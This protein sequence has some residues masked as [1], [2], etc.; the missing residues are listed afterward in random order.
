MGIV[1]ERAGP[2][3]CDRLGFTLLEE[4]DSVFDATQVD[5]VASQVMAVREG[6]L[7]ENGNS[8]LGASSAG[9]QL[10]DSSTRPW[11]SRIVS[12]SPIAV[13]GLR[14]RQHHGLSHRCWA[15]IRTASS[16][17]MSS[18]RPTPSVMSTRAVARSQSSIPALSRVTAS[19][20]RPCRASRRAKNSS[21]I[22]PVLAYGRAGTIASS[23]APSSPAVPPRSGRP[24]TSPWQRTEQAP[25][26]P[27]LADPGHR[28]A[29]PT[30]ARRTIP[31]DWPEP[32]PPHCGRAQEAGRPGAEECNRTLSG[33]GGRDRQRP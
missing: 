32:P 29:A 26:T 19:S 33:P 8:L 23:A 25:P 22:P 3:R 9:E 18:S 24:A 4:Y 12:S 30:P 27:A 10:S 14:P 16:A 20:I 17:V 21:G 2:D 11:R 1:E 28:A 7:F 13:S 15:G 31:L 5:E 6:V